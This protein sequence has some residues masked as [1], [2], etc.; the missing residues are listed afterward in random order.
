MKL[1]I[2]I[3]TARINGLA[4]KFYYNEYSACY[5]WDITFSNASTILFNS[6]FSINLGK[7]EKE[8]NEFLSRIKRNFR[9]ADIS[10]KSNVVVMFSPDGYIKAITSI[11][12]KDCWIDFNDCFYKKSFIELNI[13]IVSLVIY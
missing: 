4:D 1:P 11:G 5:S 6:V 9:K 7:T 8:A 3:A 12:G 2:C 13:S 10:E